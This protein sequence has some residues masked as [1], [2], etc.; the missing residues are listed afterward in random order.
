MRVVR[1]GSTAFAVGGITAAAAFALLPAGLPADALYLVVA[2]AA[3][4]AALVGI[5]ANR[6]PVRAPWYLLAGGFAAF[7]AGGFVS[8]VAPHVD[9]SAETSVAGDAVALAGYP[10]VLA[11]LL[12]VVHARTPERDVN[13]LVDATILTCGAALLA[14]TFL[15][16][17]SARDASLTGAEHLMAVLH[18]IGAVL[19]IALLARLAVA[20]AP[21]SHSFRLLGAALGLLV[22]AELT[23]RLIE[24]DGNGASATVVDTS[25]L[26]AFVALGLAA[27]H[28]SMATLTA[29]LPE[30]RDEISRRRIALLLAASV[31]TPAVLAAQAAGGE[32][33]AVPMIVAG[34]VLLL[35]LV[36]VRVAGLVGRHERAVAREA[37]LR[38]AAASLVEA[39]DRDAIAAAADRSARALADEADTEVRWTR[40]VDA[41]ALPARLLERL[42]AHGAAE[43]V[44][45][46][47]TRLG[48]W[49][50]HV[51][52]AP[53]VVGDHLER[54]LV[55]ALEEPP[56][57]EL[58][59]G[60]EFL[61]AQVAL[62]LEGA[63]LA[64]ER[65]RLR[66]EARF[67]SLVQNS[68]DVVAI[69]EEDTAIR[70]STPS[71]S[72]VLGF[73]DDALVGRPLIDLVHPDDAADLLERLTEAPPTPRATPAFDFR[74][75]RADGSWCRLEAVFSDL[76]DDPNVGG[77]VVTLR[78]VTERHALEQQ[79]AEQAF[80]DPLTGL[81]NRALFADRLEHS[82][83]R[84]PWEARW[85]ALLFLDLDDFKTVNDALGHT[86]GDELLTEIACRVSEAIRPGD[87]CARLGGDEFAV[88]LDGM[89]TPDD[90]KALAHDV[91]EAVRRPLRLG[92]HDVAVRTSVGLAS[93][94][95]GDLTATELLR[96][97][98]VAM[99]RAKGLGKDRIVVYDPTMHEEAL[100]RLELKARLDE[101][102][103]REELTLAYQPIVS[104]DDDR[105][106]GFEALVRW[107]LVDGRTLMPADFVPL[108]EESTLILP[109]GSWVLRE[110]C[111]RLRDWLRG[112][113]VERELFVSVNLSVHQ[114]RDERLADEVAG[115]IASAAVPP[116]ALVLEM[117]ESAVM[118]D[119]ELAGAQLQ[120][121]KELGVRLALDDFGTG[122]SSLSQL[123]RFPF[124]MLKIAKPFVDTIAASSTDARLARTVV[125]LGDTLALQTVAEGVESADQWALLRELGCTY[126]Q[127]YHFARPLPAR[128]AATL[129]ERQTTAVA[130]A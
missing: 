112:P 51:V 130:A 43:A 33:F 7:A 129:V 113:P 77:I 1:R 68:S 59:N 65:H 70:F 24:V 3:L 63:A 108:A 45:P 120:R 56:P 75:R 72:T 101:A 82:L 34:S 64:E 62:A 79:L 85:I 15:I 44:G 26:I 58:R 30:R 111:A 13:A 2:G 73:G 46:E 125:R 40:L 29:P 54:A 49:D 116:K 99:Y 67:R 57:D 27:L 83:G 106:A 6:P 91:V 19:V 48:A 105:V 118:H 35:F 71:S 92:E 87:T 37:L 31:A 100:Q 117:T 96:D 55:V 14:R 94:R 60:L 21:R 89:D 119:P 28:P 9:S 36:V 66:S 32:H 8:L 78:D 93:A 86:A 76:T 104:L 20:P 97:A 122:Y 5:S 11:A 90:A 23:A 50:A 18:P 102:I 10:L 69:I 121:L 128:D 4:G 16:D 124:D 12:L 123:R 42:G 80:R 17:P 103:E 110:A 114:L 61:G 22:A 47:A 109:L 98:D 127:G 74:A 52:V 81:A 39:A 25:R 88:L 41:A 126:G 95:P 53:L 107:P 115:A 38:R 84:E